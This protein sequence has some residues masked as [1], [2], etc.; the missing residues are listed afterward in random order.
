MGFYMPLDLDSLSGE[1]A[2]LQVD[3]GD[4]KDGPVEPLL[5][6]IKFGYC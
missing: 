4:R 2:T 1:V 3:T 5:C 6:D